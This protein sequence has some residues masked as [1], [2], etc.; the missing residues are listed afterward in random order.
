MET[1]PLPFTIQRVNISIMTT[2]ILKKVQNNV[3][4]LSCLQ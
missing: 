2:G 4:V 1:L 3:I